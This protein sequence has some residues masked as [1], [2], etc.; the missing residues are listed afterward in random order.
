M[1]SPNAGARGAP[2]TNVVA[3]TTGRDANKYSPDEGR[4]IRLAKPARRSHHAPAMHPSP[5]ARAASQAA[6]AVELHERKA[7]ATMAGVA[8]S[9]SWHCY[10]AVTRDRAI[11]FTRQTSGGM[12]GAGP[13]RLLATSCVF[14]R[15]RL[16][17]KAQA[18]SEH[19]R[20]AEQS[21]ASCAVSAR[22]A[23]RDGIDPEMLAA[24]PEQ[25]AAPNR[26]RC[27]FTPSSATRALRQMGPR[28]TAAA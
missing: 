6:T 2:I 12:A 19:P 5:R 14:A 10:D 26:E 25:V 22:R 17:A 16:V 21:S 28:S 4:G 7:I 27:P 15:L 20:A 18:G 3:T 13:V 8:R 1:P 11:A 24:G 23:G 9:R